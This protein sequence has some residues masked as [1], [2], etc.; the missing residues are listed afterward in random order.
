MCIVLFSL[1]FFFASLFFFFFFSPSN[2][3]AFKIINALEL[4]LFPRHAI[5]ID[6][7]KLY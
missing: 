1:I 6:K 2:L 5:D 3:S 7:E 4:T